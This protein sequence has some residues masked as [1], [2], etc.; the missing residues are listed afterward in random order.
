MVLKPFFSYFGSKYQVTKHYPIPKHN[1]LIEP[2]AGSA[3]YA[4]HYPHKK[5]KLYDKYDAILWILKK[6]EILDL[7]LIELDKIMLNRILVS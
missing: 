1:I 2:F 7:L 3:C 5:V 6:E 4:L